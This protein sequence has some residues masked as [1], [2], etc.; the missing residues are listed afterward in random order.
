[1]R[2]KE[3]EP[4]AMFTMP[5]AVQ[6]TNVSR[7]KSAIADHLINNPDCLSNYSRQRFS[8]IAYARSDY[9]LRMLEAVYITSLR[10]N[11]CLQKQFVA[12]LQIFRGELKFWCTS[13]VLSVFL[14][15]F[16]LCSW[17][18]MLWWVRPKRPS[19]YSSFSGWSFVLCCIKTFFCYHQE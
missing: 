9:H 10:P 11:L 18:S 3:H 2:I 12:T 6:S 4:A 5:A 16:R 19:V 15:N 17:R 7:E 14:S 13:F 8:V 1:M